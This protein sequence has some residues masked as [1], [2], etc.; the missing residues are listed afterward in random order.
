MTRKIFTVITLFLTSLSLVFAQNPNFRLSTH[1][2]D[3]KTI[4]KS[5]MRKSGIASYSLSPH[6][7]NT[8]KGTSE[9]L[10]AIG[11]FGARN[12]MLDFDKK[13]TVDKHEENFYVEIM[14]GAHI[15]AY[16]FSDIRFRFPIYIHYIWPLMPLGLPGFI[17]TETN[18]AP[19]SFD[20]GVYGNMF[21]GAN[22]VIFNIPLCSG[23]EFNSES[24]DNSASFGPFIGY[25]FLRNKNE[26]ITVV[27]SL[28][29]QFYDYAKRGWSFRLGI[30]FEDI[31]Y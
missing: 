16:N 3:T 2:Q 8:S 7:E 19:F 28:Q 6:L 12:I 17:S 23:F 21:Y 27:P 13:D 9:V 14:L 1:F 10:I 25:S 11:W 24:Y 20:N 22:F 18:W 31:N 4:D 30:T 26:S 15:K 5:Y 29:Y